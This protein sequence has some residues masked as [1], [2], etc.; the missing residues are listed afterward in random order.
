[1]KRSAALRCPV[2]H[3]RAR[4]GLFLS[5][6]NLHF[7]GLRA[8]LSAGR[9]G[10]PP[11]ARSCPSISWQRD[12]SMAGLL[13]RPEPP[14][15]G[16][17]GQPLQG[18]GHRRPWA[19]EIAGTSSRRSIRRRNRGLALLTSPAFPRRIGWMWPTS[20]TQLPVAQRR[21]RV[22]HILASPCR[23]FR[24]GA[25]RPWAG[26]GFSCGRGWIARRS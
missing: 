21:Q 25:R 7:F 1:M 12:M 11:K 6:G 8:V 22:V 24:A 15:A 5:R 18:S 16:A 13:S 23:A 17:E 9:S 19:A 2:R 10:V 4:M 26:G 14:E 3:G 20:S